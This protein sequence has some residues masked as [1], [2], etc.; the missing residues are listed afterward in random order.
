MRLLP[1][2]KGKRGGEAGGLIYRA[3]LEVR[4]WEVRGPGTAGPIDLWRMGAFSVLFW[5]GSVGPTRKVR[6]DRTAT[7]ATGG[8][9]WNGTERCRTGHGQRRRSLGTEGKTMAAGSQYLEG[10]AL[11]RCLIFFLSLHTVRPIT[12]KRF[13]RVL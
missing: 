10:C 11:S 1:G 3:E 5:V 4:D 7:L 13:Y 6:W 12:L 2:G 9:E 8:M